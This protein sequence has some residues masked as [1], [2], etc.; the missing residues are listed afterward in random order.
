SRGRIC[1]QEILTEFWISLEMLQIED[2]PLQIEFGPTSLR[3]AISV[4]QEVNHARQVLGP[5]SVNLNRIGAISHGCI[6]NF[7]EA[8]EDPTPGVFHPR[9]IQV[10]HKLWLS[11]P[12]GLIAHDVL[13]DII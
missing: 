5:P 6:M 1:S 7:G 13:E 8:F 10:H 12:D 9:D 2:Q 11:Q 4:P 3:T